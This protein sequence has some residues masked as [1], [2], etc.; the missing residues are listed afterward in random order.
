MD[1]IAKIAFGVDFDSLNNPKSE[2]SVA[3]DGMQE[4]IIERVKAPFILFRIKR[5][6][7]IGAE[8]LLR[9]HADTLN[10]LVSHIIAER[11]KVSPFLFF[12]SLSPPFF[13]EC[14]TIQ[15]LDGSEDAE[16]QWKDLLSQFVVMSK[17]RHEVMDEKH[18]R[19]VIMNFIIGDPFPL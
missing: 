3:F 10:S 7:R 5:F 16:R 19:D 6:L 8:R 13:S 11:Q 14:V 12:C 9:S 2:F 4:L 18:V 15:S 1:S 17:K